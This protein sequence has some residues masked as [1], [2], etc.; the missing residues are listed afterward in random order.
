MK[1]VWSLEEFGLLIKS[2]S[3]RIKNKAAEQK[4]G[5]LNMLLI[6]LGASILGNLLAGKDVIRTGQGT[7]K[8]DQYF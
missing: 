2:F 3:K 4:R 8:A 6:T 7:I 1:V 5:F